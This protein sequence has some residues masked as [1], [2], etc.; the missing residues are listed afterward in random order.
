M[1]GIDNETLSAYKGRVVSMDDEGMQAVRPFLAQKKIEY[2]VVIG[3]DRLAKLYNLTSMPMTL[4][5]DRHGKIA[6]SHT[7]I[8]GKNDFES[9]IQN[10]LKQ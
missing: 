3:N 5:I 9:H 8:V 1:P 6:V 4:L 2:P 7:G 10:L